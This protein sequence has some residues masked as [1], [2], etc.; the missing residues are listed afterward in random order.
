L[1]C[2]QRAAT[3]VLKSGLDPAELGRIDVRLDVDKHGNVTSHLTVERPATL[4]MLRN[5]APRLQQALEDAGLKT[6]DSGLQFSLRDRSSGRDGD[7]GSGHNAQRVVIAEEDTIPRRSRDGLTDACSDRAAASI[8]G[9]EEITMAVD[10]AT[11]ATT[12]TSAPATTTGSSSKSNSSGT[13][14]ATLADNFQSFLLLLTTQL[15]NQNP[16]DPLDTNQ[17]TQQLVQF[18]QVEQQLKSNSQ[19]ESLVKSSRPRNRRRRWCSSARPWRS[20]AAPRISMAM[21]PG[22]STHHRARM[23]PSPSPI[24]RARPLIQATSPSAPAI[25]ALSGTARATTVRS[26]PRVTTR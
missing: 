4:D 19:L 8:S 11:I 10:A 23:R 1:R 13:S 12:P 20:T 14:G 18:A 7:N 9:S 6:G 2:A 16:L 21:R 3:A 5:D 17:F 15:Q 22:I 24:R 25:P 26:G